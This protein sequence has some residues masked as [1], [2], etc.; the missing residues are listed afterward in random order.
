[1]ER[2]KPADVGMDADSLNEAIHYAQTIETAWPRKMRLH[3][4]EMEKEESHP[5]VIGSIKDRGATNGLI[6]R[7][8]YII[9]EW[10]ETQR[11]D[12]TFSV[13]KSYLSTMQG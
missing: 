6:L 12:M 7:H 2:R 3:Y 11:V 1:M 9:A 13:S 5:E 8:G 10:G 4:A